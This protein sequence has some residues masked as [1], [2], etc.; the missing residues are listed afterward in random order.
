M[1]REEYITE[2]KTL[3]GKAIKDDDIG[4]ALSILERGRE[5]DIEDI[6]GEEVKES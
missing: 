3:Y 6:R 4:L 1:K 2:L 5:M